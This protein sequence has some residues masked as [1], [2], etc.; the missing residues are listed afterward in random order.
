M[1]QMAFGEMDQDGSKSIDKAEF[2]A[3]YEEVFHEKG[4]KFKLSGYKVHYANPL[5]LIIKNMLCRKFYCQNGL[6]QLSFHIRLG[7]MDQDGSKSIDK[8]EFLAFYEE[9][10]TRDSSTSSWIR[11][12]E[13]LT[14]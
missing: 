11:Q 9:L 7:T 10:S 5:I 8:A 2:L 12:L 1:F 14:R 13:P 6:V 4:I 3:F